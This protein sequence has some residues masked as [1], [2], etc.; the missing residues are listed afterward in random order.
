MCLCLV[1]YGWRKSAPTSNTD[2]KKHEVGKYQGTLSEKKKQEFSFSLFNSSNFDQHKREPGNSMS[3]LGV[4][5]GVFFA[6]G[7]VCLILVW[8]IVLFL[9]ADTE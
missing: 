8:I 2:K 3:C 1:V 5:Q 6:S 7:F 4:G 9:S